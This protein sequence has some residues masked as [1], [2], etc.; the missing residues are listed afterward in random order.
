VC[1]HVHRLV[2]PVNLDC[3]CVDADIEA[4]PV[5]QFLRRGQ[6]QGVALG[7]GAADVERQAA[8]AE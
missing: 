8:V 3:L 6:E 5:Q 4:V 7:D 1:P 2:L